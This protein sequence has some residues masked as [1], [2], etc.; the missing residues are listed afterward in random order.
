MHL[1][2]LGP[3]GCGKGTQARHLVKHLK[4]HHLSTG[5][6]LRQA[7][8]TPLG[9]QIAARIDGGNFVSDELANRL[10]AETFASRNLQHGCIFDG[11][12]RTQA[13]VP[14]LDTLLASF[15]TALK[16]AIL[17]EVDDEQIVWR[18]TG[19]R[20]DPQTGLIYHI[21]DKIP[22][23]VRRR[24]IQRPDDTATIARQRL[25][26]YRQRTAPVIELY[27]ADTRLLAIDGDQ[28]PQRVL[29]AILAQ[30]GTPV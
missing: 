11:Y 15:G 12:P 5:D 1:V 4:S 27:R 25:E 21:D 22:A 28:P 13:Q 3:P 18:L 26:I 8:D 29:A 16:A 6:L 17:L 24:L 2:L 30:L 10:V 23:P 9:R 19:R 14:V 7:G 20:H